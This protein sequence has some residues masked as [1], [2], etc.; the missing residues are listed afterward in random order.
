MN[1]SRR[2]AMTCTACHE[3]LAEVEEGVVG[4]A[5]TGRSGR[6]CL[7][8]FNELE[9]GKVRN[10]NVTFHGGSRG[11]IDEDMGSYRTNAVREMEDGGGQ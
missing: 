8:C 5:V 1:N 7:D 4:R 11:R 9:H 2:L 6:Y 3:Q 10:Q